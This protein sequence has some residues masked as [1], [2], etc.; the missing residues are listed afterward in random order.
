MPSQYCNVAVGSALQSGQNAANWPQMETTLS[1]R[2]RGAVT[3][4]LQLDC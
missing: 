1:V 3:Q 4:G 2:I